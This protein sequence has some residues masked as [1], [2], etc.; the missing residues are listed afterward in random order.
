[1][2]KKSVNRNKKRARSFRN[3]RNLKN[4]RA[5]R[6]LD[7]PLSIKID[8]IFFYVVGV[9]TFIFGLFVF[10]GALIGTAFLSNVDKETMLQT[11]PGL[12][13]WEIALGQ[14]V[15]TALIFVGL[16]ICMWGIIQFFIGKE[17]WKGK[18]IA[19]IAAA[20]LIFIGFLSSL[21]V[22]LSLSWSGLGGLA[23]YGIL[24]YCLFFDKKARRFFDIDSKIWKVKNRVKKRKR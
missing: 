16:I 21:G 1:M 19:Y 13:M 17:L 14:G 5:F 10:F 18:K 7:P 4:F 6:V 24:G 23:I 8:S 9:L 12:S 11:V 22:V 2:P 15:L 20:I 3:V